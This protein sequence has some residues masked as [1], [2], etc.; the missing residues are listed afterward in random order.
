M[1][2]CVDALLA[3]SPRTPWSARVHALL[4]APTQAS[5]LVSRE[6]RSV[7]QNYCWILGLSRA[8]LLMLSASVHL[9][10][11]RSDLEC[12]YAHPHY[13]VIV[14]RQ[15][16][17]SIGVEDPKVKMICRDFTCGKCLRS[18]NECRFLH[19]SSA[20]DCAIVCQDFLRGRCDR[21]SC[22][23]SH[24][25]A[26]P[27]PPMGH[28]PIQYPD[29]Y[30]QL[31]VPPPPPPLGV[32]MM[33]PHPSPPRPYADNKNTM[34]VCMDFLKN[35]CN[36]ESCRF[37]HPDAH[38]GS[39]CPALRCCYCCAA[40]A[41]A[42]APFCFCCQR[43]A[44]L[45]V[46]LLRYVVVSDQPSSVGIKGFPSPAPSDHC[47]GLSMPVTS[48]SNADE[49]ELLLFSGGETRKY[50]GPRS[51]AQ[52]YWAIAESKGWFGNDESVRSRALAEEHARDSFGNLLFSVCRFRELTGRYPEKITVVSYDFK[53]ERF[54]QLHRTALL[55][56]EGRFF[57]SGTPATP[58]ARE[59]AMKGEAAVR[60]QFLEDPYGCL[61]SLSMRRSSRGIH[62]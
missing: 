43:A 40:T 11:S 54:A 18:A 15:L 25:V 55:F 17:R 34:E 45:A 19:H 3:G 8:R 22:S 48:A 57:L 41:A 38:T 36:R 46:V 37:A 32:P 39:E 16:L 31:Y 14:D 10:C 20:E 28:I 58:A 59:A 49:A 12:R 26:Q 2:A 13:P 30:S 7:D 6:A 21:K 56:L 47:P 4:R 62:S 29:V 44:A 52:S 5:I 50:A 53:E 61:G 51:E 33:G 1:A 35:V 23:Y 9:L 60:S 24:V 27:V 42:A